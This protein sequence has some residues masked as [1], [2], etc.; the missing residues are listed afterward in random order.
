MGKPLVVLEDTKNRLTSLK[1]YRRETYDEVIV[2]LLDLWD[3]CEKTDFSKNV[4]GHVGV[5]N[6]V[7]LC[8][9]TKKLAKDIEEMENRTVIKEDVKSE[10][11]TTEAEALEKEITSQSEISSD[12][13]AA[14]RNT[15]EDVET[16]PS[17]EKEDKDTIK[18]A[19][20]VFRESE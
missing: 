16:E 13:E 10:E 11:P 9:R 5:P 4:D 2:R 18:E 7:P 15:E 3:K 17:E 6:G 12:I 14:K 8:D 19:E 1:R 20:N